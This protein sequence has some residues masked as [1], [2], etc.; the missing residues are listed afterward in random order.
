MYG[1]GYK[2]TLQRKKDNHILSHSTGANDAANLALAG[3]VFIDDIVFYVPLYTPN[4]SNRKIML[5]HIVSE[6]AT[7]SSYI[8]GSS[9]MKDVT[10]ENSWTFELSVGDG[11]DIPI[12]VIVGFMQ[13]DHFNRK[14]QKNVAFYG[15]S[16]VISQ[17]ISGSEI[18]P[19]AGINSNYAFDRSS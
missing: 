12:Y 15:P 2:L 14:H 16:V 7:E 18:F 4:L 13:R 6:T 19:D 5:G 10:T 3:R 8:N 11:I 9:Y 17:I 1:L